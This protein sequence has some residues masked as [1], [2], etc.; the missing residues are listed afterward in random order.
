M[1]RRAPA[2]PTA[3]PER[4]PATRPPATP[5]APPALR[6]VLSPAA[7]PHARPSAPPTGAPVRAADGERG[8]CMPTGLINCM[9]C[10]KNHHPPCPCAAPPAQA[11]DP[12]WP[13]EPHSHTASQPQSRCLPDAPILLCR[14]AKLPVPPPCPH[15]QRQRLD[16]AHLQPAHLLPGVRGRPLVLPNHRQRNLPSMPRQVVS[17]ARPWCRS[18]DPERVDAAVRDH[19]S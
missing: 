19:L 14:H 3:G 9:P 17:T 16:G 5:L 11:P 6:N 1:R 10:P 15:P 12:A 7:R 18:L 4:R 13:G 2:A 8:V